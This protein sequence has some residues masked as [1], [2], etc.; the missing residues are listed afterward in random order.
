MGRAV[1]VVRFDLRA[2][3][4][5]WAARDATKAP[6]EKSRSFILA[7]CDFPSCCVL[8]VGLFSWVAMVRNN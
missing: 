4:K 1:G 5:P 3:W 8:L 2:H 6:R 7:G